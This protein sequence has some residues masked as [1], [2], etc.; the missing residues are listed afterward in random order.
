MSRDE[1]KTKAQ[2]IG[3]LQE[4]RRQL[5]ELGEPCQPGMNARELKLAVEELR[6]SEKRYRELIDSVTDYIYSVNVKNGVLL[7][8]SPGPGCIAVTGYPPGDYERD[9]DLWHKM[10]H[11]DDREEVEG[12]ISD[13]IAGKE[14]QPFEHRI[15]H[16]DGTVRWIR[17]TTVLYFKDKKK[18]LIGYDGLV[19]DITGRRQAEE[20]LSRN[21]KLLD[22]INRAQSG[23]ISEADPHAIFNELLDDFLPL[24]ESEFGFIAELEYMEKGD[25]YLALRALTNIAWNEETRAL[26]DRFR[27]DGMEFQNMNT[28][29]GAVVKTGKV[30]ISN[31]P[32]NDPRSGGL[33]KGHPPLNSFI[34]IPYPLKGKMKGIVCAANRPGG[35]SD[36][37]VEYLKPFL[38]TCS[39]MVEAYKN[40]LI[41]QEAEE[42]IKRYA[43]ELKESNRM[44]DLFTDIMRHDLMNPANLVMNFAEILL[45]DEADPKKRDIIEEIGLNSNKLVQLIDDA[46]K[47][48]KLESLEKID[49]DTLDLGAILKETI[50]A[51]ELELEKKNMTL[52]YLPKKKYLASVNKIMGDVFSNLIANAIKYSSKGSGIDVGIRSRGKDWLVYVKD[53][54]KGI[55][56][57]DKERIFERFE[58]AAR[59][60]DKGYGLGLA[61][62]R[63]IIDL[64]G[65]RIWVEDNPDGGSIFYV[66]LKKEE[67]V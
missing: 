59:E 33:P 21:H 23:V 15:M 56:H 27:E 66:S 48:S 5:A 12:K 40:R 24:T 2:L 55:A 29:F 32:E 8:S 58:R 31:D 49:R 1:N 67:G 65:G 4:I 9:P 26:F 60:G 39:T 25:P 10:I 51:Y 54:G 43:E 47:Y 42:A 14:V 18:G 64:H 53:F 61:I 3:E 7:S 22:A 20:S 45:H 62:A 13:L 36:D 44:K 35:Y 11:E 6:E 46:S 17:N 19:R 38:A 63:R 52:R 16:K 28:L 50:H 57:K 30:V 37:I 41:R 34:G